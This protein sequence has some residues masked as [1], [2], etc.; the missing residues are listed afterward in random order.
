M[1]PSQVMVDSFGVPLLPLAGDDEGSSKPVARIPQL[2]F[3]TYKIAPENA[4]EIVENA[5]EV[6]YRHIDTAQMY[7][8]ESEVG[9]ALQA[10]GIPR[11]QVFL[12]TKL[13]NPNHEPDIARRAF[14]ESLQRLQTDYVDLFLIHW[15]M[16]EAYGGDYPG[17]WR[18]LQE[19]VAEGRARH[20]G[21][22]NFEVS[23]L[24]R[25]LNETGIFPQVNQVEAHP[26]FANNAVRDFT[27]ANGGVIEAWSPLAR[28]RFF[29]TPALLETAKRLGRTPAQVVLRWAIERGDVVIPKSNHAERMR[30][31][32]AVLEFEL[33]APARAT[34]D[35]LNRGESGRTGSH[36]DRVNGAK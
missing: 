11:S 5:L 4:Q 6:G 20:V 31:N 19:F 16:P 13:N 3:G 8:N 10:S 33:D 32:F 18:V 23:H 2:G 25:L 35:S 29:D 36:P 28:G 1:M 7:G 9:A 21:V 30:E 22:S 14:T 12:T 24:Q 26:W 17:L 27:K 15:P 34:L